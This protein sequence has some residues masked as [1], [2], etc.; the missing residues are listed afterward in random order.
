MVRTLGYIANFAKASGIRYA[1]SHS[2]TGPGVIAFFFSSNTCHRCPQ[3]RTKKLLFT[4]FY[5]PNLVNKSSYSSTYRK[6]ARTR[7]IDTYNNAP[8]VCDLNRHYDNASGAYSQEC[9]T[10][11][12]ACFLRMRAVGSVGSPGQV[13]VFLRSKR[14]M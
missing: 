11:V 2:I 1:G 4:N 9:L 14:S 10:H 5:P 3:T 12:R 7:A 8:V 6:R 13:K